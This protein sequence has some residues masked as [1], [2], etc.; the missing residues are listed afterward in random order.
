MVMFRCQK[1]LRRV[2]CTRTVLIQSL[3]TPSPSPAQPA[4]TAL[5]VT[6]F[7]S[8]VIASSFCCPVSR[9]TFCT[10]EKTVP[11]GLAYWPF[12]PPALTHVVGIF[13]SGRP[14]REYTSYRTSSAC[15][16]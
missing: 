15:A 14:L 5:G 6:W 9:A 8:T 12:A 10:A 3:S 11:S 16:K 2:D 13:T 1:A 7:S 4:D